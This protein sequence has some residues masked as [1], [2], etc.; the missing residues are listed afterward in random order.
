MYPINPIYALAY[1]AALL[2]AIPY[3]RYLELMG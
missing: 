3:W 1:I 2:L